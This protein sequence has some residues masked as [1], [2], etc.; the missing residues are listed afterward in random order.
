MAPLSPLLREDLGLGR[1]QVGWLLPAIYLGGVLMSVPAGWL[2]DRLGARLSLAAG[3]TVTGAFI[4]WAAWSPSL[5]ALLPLL[6]LAGLGW[7][8]IN[9]ATGRAVLER[10]AAAERGLAMGVKQTGLT[11]GGVTAALVLPPLAE[12]HGWRAAL[13]AAAGASL[14]SATAVLIGPG[15][16]GAPGAAAPRPR[17]AELGPYLARAPLRVLL[18]C[19]LVLSAVQSSVVA[20]LTL[21]GREALGL[22]VVAAAAVFAA[23]QVGGTLGRLGWGAVSDRFFGGRRRPGV[24]INAG[25]GAATYLV[26]ATGAPLPAPAA[27]AV[28]LLAGVGAFGWMGLYLA[29]AAEVG[30]PRHA[31]LL[32]GVAVGAAWSGVLVGP[33]LF[34]ALLEASGDYRV[35]WLALAAASAAAAVALHRLPPFVARAPAG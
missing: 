32:T 29:L 23:A 15:G 16:G 3:Q 27:A 1:A 35:P 30:G 19:G 21:F 12:A 10:F 13:G 24:V 26:F 14:L 20:Y 2:T 22:P 18:G 17:L 33:P 28:A 25:L 8:V 6:A 4:G 5:P 11:L 34:G 31:G 9:P 7:A